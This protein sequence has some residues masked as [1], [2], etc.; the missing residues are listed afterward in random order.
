MTSDNTDLNETDLGNLLTKLHQSRGL[1]FSLYKMPMLLRRIS[2]RMKRL[3]INSM[4]EYECVLESDDSEVE[5]L[6]DSLNINVTE[7]FRNPESFEMM[8]RVVIPRMVDQKLKKRHNLIRVW[9]VG[10]SE[11]DEPYSIAISFL[12]ALGE[13]LSGF[14]LT[15]M[16]SDIDRKALAAAKKRI[17]SAERLKSVPLNIREKYFEPYE[18]AF[19]VRDEVADLV[20]FEYRDIVNM[21]PHRFCDLITCRNV[22]IYFNRELQEETQLKFRE[23]LNPGGHLI[24]GMVESLV[25]SAGTRFETVDTKLRIYRRPETDSV[26]E[27]VKNILSQEEIDGLVGEILK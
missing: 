3:N 1:D 11:G 6:L 9:S 5:E 2:A 8:S 4:E 19:R 27:T 15:I 10:C 20:T 22:L 23:C 21:R 24:L 13:D 17:Y 12:E 26:D 14:M 18:K 25:G 16:A 7:F